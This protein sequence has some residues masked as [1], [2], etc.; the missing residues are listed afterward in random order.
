MLV[1]INAPSLFSSI[2]ARLTKLLDPDGTVT[3]RI[4]GDRREW[5]PFLDNLIAR[6][7]LPENLGGTAPPFESLP[8]GGYALHEGDG[9]DDVPESAIK[10]YRAPLTRKEVSHLDVT[11]ADLFRRRRLR[12]DV[13]N[14]TFAGFVFLLIVLG[15]YVTVVW[16]VAPP[17]PH[18]GA[19]RADA[20]PSLC[21]PPP[22]R[23]TSP[24]WASSW[25]G[26]CGRPWP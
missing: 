26:R 25:A 4:L 7:Q 20:R 16:I 9:V 19:S 18:G 17:S 14:L 22:A 21:F 10:P 1:I 5:Q 11:A 13:A 12:F 15:V 23:R 3:V 6:D 2:H 24:G 8:V